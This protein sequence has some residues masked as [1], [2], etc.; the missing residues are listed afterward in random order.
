MA[1]KLLARTRERTGTTGT[2]DILVSGL[3]SSDNVKFSDDMV[4]ADTSYFMVLSGDGTGWEEFYG[5]YSATNTIQRTATIINHLGTTAHVAL[6][7]TSR[8]F[9]IIPTDWVS[10]FSKLGAG[11][12]SKFL[13]GD[14]T[15]RVPAG[16]SSLAGDSDVTIAGAA[17]NDFLEYQTSDSKWHNRTPTQATAAL[18]AVVGDTG[19][20]GTKGLVPAPGAG[21]AAAGKLLGAGGSFV[22][23]YIVGWH[24]PASF[25]ATAALPACTYANGTAGVGATLTGNANGA[26]P[27]QDGVAP[28]VGYRLLVPLQA[29]AAHNGIYV[30]TQV[31]SG[32][33]PFILTRATDFDSPNNINQ[34]DVVVVGP[35]GT[36]NASK[37]FQVSANASP[38]VVGTTNLTWSRVT[39]GDKYIFAGSMTGV[40]T[41]SQLLLS[42]KFTTAVTIPANFGDHLGYSSEAGGTAV[43]T[44]S[45]VINVDKAMAATP[46]TFSN[47]GTITFAIGTVTPTFASSGGTA[48][49]FAKGDVVRLVGPA[50]ADATF[51]GFYASIVGFET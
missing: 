20:G 44:A 49:S 29:T 25:A 50:S 32:G 26:L 23:P 3:I 15:F 46:N 16:S 8:I 45:T 42:H 1:F 30:V 17:N 10:L 48:I 33:A 14:G 38:I 11:D 36:A 13:S 27:S 28:V 39:V 18:I 37:F 5:T 41:T 43:T 31:G 35:G 34:G 22:T 4:V 7:G 40:L 12:T 9:G 51:A 19:S 21:D 24:Y 2:G 47:V 6:S